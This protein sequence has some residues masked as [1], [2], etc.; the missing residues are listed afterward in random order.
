VCRSVSPR[1]CLHRFLDISK[2]HLASHSSCFIPLWRKSKEV[3]HLFPVSQMSN[4]I[5]CTVKTLGLFSTCPT[6]FVDNL[7]DKE[8]SELYDELQHFYKSL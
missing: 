5:P 1:V 3:L 7:N 6:Y 4:N 2:T 8:I